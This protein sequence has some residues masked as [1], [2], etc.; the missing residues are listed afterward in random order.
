MAYHDTIIIGAG[1]AGLQMGYF[2]Q[3]AGRDYLILEAEDQAGS[4]FA[5]Q[6][7]HRT[8]LSINK[9]FNWFSEADYN[10]RHDWNSLLTEDKT[11]LF[12]NYSEELYPQPY[13]S[14]YLIDNG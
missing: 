7:R 2:L 1:P 14:P 4:F 8:L 5:K 12:G 10:L 6:P 9:R 11:L 3:Q 13:V